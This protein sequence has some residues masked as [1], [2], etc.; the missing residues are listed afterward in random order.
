MNK[1]LNKFE[2]IYFMI[3][4]SLN[5]ELAKNALPPVNVYSI[6]Y[7]LDLTSL[8]LSSDFTYP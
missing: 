1:I 5:I 6:N 7:K 3:V 4:N 8:W 2:L